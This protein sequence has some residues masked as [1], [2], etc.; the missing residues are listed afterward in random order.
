MC[1]RGQTVHRDAGFRPAVRSAAR[2][3][4]WTCPGDAEPPRISLPSADI[5]A[6]LDRI[7]AG[8][9]DLYLHGVR[10]F[11]LPLRSYLADQLYDQA[12][13][14]DLAQEVFEAKVLVKR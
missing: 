12:E 14:N 8:E 3:A 4:H 6:L 13:A 2:P 10:R 5:D 11:E 9:T 7:A 1:P